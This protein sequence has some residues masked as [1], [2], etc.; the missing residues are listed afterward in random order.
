MEGPCVAAESA[1]S[2]PM[3]KSAPEAVDLR[4]L[5]AAA[6]GMK[7]GGVVRPYDADH[8]TGGEASAAV[9]AGLCQETGAEIGLYPE[10]G[11]ISPQDHS[12][13]LGVAPGRMTGS[14]RTTK[15][16]SVFDLV[17]R[18]QL[19][20]QAFFLFILLITSCCPLWTNYPINNLFE[21]TLSQLQD[22]FF[23]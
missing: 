10:K 21:L 18:I 2:C 7:T 9:A 20:I 12:H 19:F 23:V 6:H 3:G 11:T 14:K 8:R 16:F 22:F 5:G 13:D 15:D 17:V 4:H 1:L